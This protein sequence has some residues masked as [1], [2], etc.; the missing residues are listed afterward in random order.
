MRPITL[1][2]GKIDKSAPVWPPPPT[3]ASSTGP[4][5]T[6]EKILS[7]FFEHHRPVLETVLAR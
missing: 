4:A 6:L 5:G 7:H 1:S 3:V 2:S